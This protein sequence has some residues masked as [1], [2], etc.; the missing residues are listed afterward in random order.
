[1]ITKSV[2]DELCRSFIS[3]FKGEK[4]RFS[5]CKIGPGNVP[6]YCVML[7]LTLS[8]VLSPLHAVAEQPPEQT[9][10]TFNAALLE[11]MKKA[12]ELGYKGRHA[13]LA[14]VI[15]NSFALPFMADVALG[16]YRSTLTDEQR[17]SYLKTYAEW[18]TATYA[19]RFDGYSG[20]RFEIVSQSEPERGIVTVISKLVKPNCEEVEFDYLLRNISGKWRIVDI[21]ISG[22]SQLALTRAQFTKVIKDEGFTGLLSMLTEK[23]KDFSQGKGK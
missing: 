22:V 18:T 4:M 13:L 23:T 15:D 10:R 6:V 20:E 12:G 3:P 11:A 2:I 21:H 8:F 17:N 14:P 19:G 16:R 9:I 1:M 7:L 5:S